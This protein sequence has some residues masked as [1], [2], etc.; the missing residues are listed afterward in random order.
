VLGKQNVRSHQQGKCQPSFTVR[1]KDWRQSSAR[2]FGLFRGG[3]VLQENIMCDGGNTIGE[4]VSCC[5]A[6]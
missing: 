5:V 1:C 3:G 2:E 4:W 6:K